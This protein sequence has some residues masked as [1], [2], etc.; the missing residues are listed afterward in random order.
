MHIVA[1]DQAAKLLEHE[2][3]PISQQDLLQVIPVVEMRD[4]R[5]LEHDAEQHRQHDPDDDRDEQ[6]PSERRQRERHV[7]AHHVETAMGEID[8][9]HDPEDQR[10]AARDQEQQQAVLDAVQ[11]LD[12]ERVDVHCVDFACTLLSA[13]LRA[14]HAHGGTRRPAC[15][16]CP[17]PYPAVLH[18]PSRTSGYGHGH[19]LGAAMRLGAE[20]MRPS[21]WIRAHPAVRLGWWRTAGEPGVAQPSPERAKLRDPE[22]ELAAARRIGDVLH[23]HAD[24]LVLLAF[25]LAQ[26]DVVDRRV[27]LGERKGAARAVELRRFHCP[28]DVGTFRQVT[29]DGVGAR[30]QQLRG[31]VALDR[32]Y[33]GLDLVRLHV[34]RAERRVLRIVDARLHSA[35]W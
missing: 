4:E 17:W 34:G 9:A 1:D 13:P 15:S 2:D 27:G 32:V 6:V 12:Q 31:V 7:R 22:S 29:L 25:D 14:V 3:E 5:P 16:A 28:H 23:R 11:Q 26:V 8:D 30:D 19:A 21:A 10:E 35:T 33:V 18:H 24:D 20:A